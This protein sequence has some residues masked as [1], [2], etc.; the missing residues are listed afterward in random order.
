MHLSVVKL[1]CNEDNRQ[2]NKDVVTY[3]EIKD[4]RVDHKKKPTFL[5][6]TQDTCHL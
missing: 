6:E 1:L 2:Q 4:T 5:D 3:T